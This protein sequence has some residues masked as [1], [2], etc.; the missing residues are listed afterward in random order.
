MRRMTIKKSKKFSEISV[1][2]KLKKN[3]SRYNPKFFFK[4]QETS[5]FGLKV[6]L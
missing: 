1:R 2:K 6:K 5:S 4:S 3:V